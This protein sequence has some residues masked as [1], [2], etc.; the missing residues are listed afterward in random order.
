MMCPNCG[1]YNLPGNEVCS[2]CHQDLTNVDQHVPQNQIERS[3]M[4]KTVSVLDLQP[5]I[6]IQPTAT[7]QE[8][9][10]IMLDR[11]VGAVLVVDENHNLIGIFS[12]RD[13]L[14]KVA[15]IHEN[16]GSLSLGDFMTAN[17][18][19]IS[20]SDKLNFALHRMDVGGYRHIPV[21]EDGKPRGMLSVRD[22]L[23]YITKVCE[24][25]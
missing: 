25:N 7:I 3:L 12:E 2:N 14:K 22:M 16:Y 8:A 5:P 6:I 4:E 15:G 24:E 17:P 13:L 11:N 21:V 1:T 23:T 9:M 18:E 10:Q 20:P 19:T